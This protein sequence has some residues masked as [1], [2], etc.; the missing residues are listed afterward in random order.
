MMVSGV[1]YGSAVLLGSLMSQSC[2]LAPPYCQPLHAGSGEELRWKEKEDR[3]RALTQSLESLKQQMVGRE[4]EMLRHYQQL[5]REVSALEGKL[6]R[7]EEDFLSKQAALIQSYDDKMREEEARSGKEISGLRGQLVD[8]K[9]ELA[10]REEV[11]ER[12]KTELKEERVSQERSSE[13]SKQKVEK[14]RCMLV[15][16]S[17]ALYELVSS[18]GAGPSV[19]ESRMRELS[20]LLQ[21]EMEVLEGQ[22][23]CVVCASAERAVVL[24]PCRHHQLCDRCASL[25]SIC[26]SCRSRISNRIKVFT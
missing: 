16:R 13:V 6:E 3:V 11:A 20:Q 23:L 21:E 5:Q 24:M 17:S 12:L 15:E 9:S 4:S 19:S 18:Q 14:L 22:R 8:V 25:L 26:P 1:T 7:G 10:H 2:S